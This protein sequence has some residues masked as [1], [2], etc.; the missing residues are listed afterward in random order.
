MEQPSAAPHDSVEARDDCALTAKGQAIRIPILDND[1]LSKDSRIVLA[2]AGMQDAKRNLDGTIT[3]FAEDAGPKVFTYE[4]VRGGET[5]AAD[6][7]LLVNSKPVDIDEPVFAAPGRDLYQREPIVAD[8][9]WDA[10]FG[11]PEMLAELARACS[12]AVAHRLK[13]IPAAGERISEGEALA[14][15]VPESGE[16]VQVRMELSPK[17]HLIDETFKNAKYLAVDDGLLIITQ[18]GRIVFL[19]DFF[20]VK[21]AEISIPGLPFF[22]SDVLLANL[23]PLTPDDD[24]KLIQLAGLQGGGAGYAGL[25]VGASGES[26]LLG[27][28]GQ[29]TLSAAIGS[30][31][32]SGTFILGAQA[33]DQLGEDV[34]IT[35]AL[36]DSIESPLE[37]FNPIDRDVDILKKKLVNDFT[38]PDF[39]RDTE[40]LVYGQTINGH[41]GEIFTVSLNSGQILQI[42]VSARSGGSPLLG[43]FDRT[44][45]G[46]NGRHDGNGDILVFD[47]GDDQHSRLLYESDGTRTVSILVIDFEDQEGTFDLRVQL[48]QQPQDDFPSGPANGVRIA[49]PL[50]INE[51]IDFPADSDWF[52]IELCAGQTYRFDL[53]G[54]DTGHGTLAD[55]LLELHDREGHLFAIDD[56]GGTGRNSSL[57]FTPGENGTFFLAANE[58]ADRTGGYRLTAE[59]VTLSD[60]IPD[61]NNTDAVLASNGEPRVSA[62]DFPGD[63]DWFRIEQLVAGQTYQFQVVGTAGQGALIDPVLELRDETGSIVAFN[64]DGPGVGLNSLLIFTPAVSGEFLLAASGFADTT[65]NYQVTADLLERD[66]PGNVETPD[67]LRVGEANPGTIQFPYDSDWFRIRLE[68]GETY[69]F[70]LV[71]SEGSLP[72]VFVDLFD[73]NGNLVALGSSV[74]GVLV[75][76][77]GTSGTFFVAVTDYVG[78]MKP[79]AYAVR[80][81]LFEP[82]LGDVPGN[83]TTT[84]GLESDGTQQGSTIDFPTDS[85]WF[86]IELEA[87]QVYQFDLVGTDDLLDLSFVDLYDA[88]GN[89]V[90]AGHQIGDG[91]GS[92]LLFAPERTGDFFVA[93]TDIFGESEPVSYVVSA[94]P[95][96]TAELVVGSQPQTGTIDSPFGS[97]W[98]RIG[99]EAD[100]TYLIDLVGSE[101]PLQNTFVDLFDDQGNLV[102]LGSAGEQGLNSFLVFAPETSGEYLVSVTDFQGQSAVLPYTL[103]AVEMPSALAIQD[104]LGDGDLVGDFAGT[105]SGPIPGRGIAERDASSEV[106]PPGSDGLSPSVSGPPA[107]A[108]DLRLES[109]IGS[110]DV[111]TA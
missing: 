37:I 111:A 45:T 38:E 11:E 78:E 44:E 21:E 93:V 84:I 54:A 104:I 64:D 2:L 7:F 49:T 46:S 33:D 77:P 71:G 82:P 6:V 74:G 23:Q 63:S 69:R 101:T 62:I 48:L 88:S 59:L 61:Q 97:D 40:I 85:D 79:V 109:I 87:D 96:P 55:P 10:L 28:P 9:P 47:G 60:D 76:A 107:A 80:A 18:D 95:L 94:V 52:P 102:A 91:Q 50:P 41:F 67:T 86:Q 39:G 98:F 90:A 5:A 73:A 51:T 68:A 75:F 22:G 53:E 89:L 81:A 31:F 92:R 108:P 20:D 27:N 17:V 16:F 13:M 8:T 4:I 35:G 1:V 110:S 32:S 36:E 24:V 29:D 34:A 66:V 105:G 43:I 99:L 72:G 3:A 58:F 42:D 15:P 30:G 19:A 25:L 100:Q 14:I 70:D 57:F 106:G 26:G 12:N 65:G 103:S 83:T 56:D